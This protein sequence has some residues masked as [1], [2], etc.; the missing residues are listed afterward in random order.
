MTDGD[1]MGRQ[2]RKRGFNE[3][4][5]WAARTTMA[6]VSGLK[7]FTELDG[8]AE[9]KWTW[10]IPL[11]I[12]YLTPLGSW[13]PYNLVLNPADTIAAENGRNGGFT[14]A[15]AFQGSSNSVFYRTPE[16]F[17][18]N[19][20]GGDAA[21]TTQDVVGVLDPGGVIRRC[22]AS[23]I[24]VF[25]PPIPNVGQMVRQRFPIAPLHSKKN[26]GVQQLYALKHAMSSAPSIL[27][28]SF[29]NLAVSP[30]SLITSSG[31][32]VTRHIHDV[33]IVSADVERLTLLQSIIVDTDLANTHTHT[34][35]LSAR[36]VGDQLE[37]TQL[38]CDGAGAVC[39]DGHQK[40]CRSGS[41]CVV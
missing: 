20:S 27:N 10:A 12:I 18:G 21:D 17:F 15:T 11:E 37:Y 19:S 2:S 38:D 25:F 14:A 35:R 1:A 39:P 41:T 13:N 34:L 7:V 9:E 4:T 8:Y 26:P 6:K 36:K 16:V 3:D 31:S 23:G 32:D 24:W 22:R 30:A 28:G 5:M 29:V 40:V 33:F